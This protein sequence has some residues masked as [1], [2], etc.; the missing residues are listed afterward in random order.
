MPA[1]SRDGLAPD[2]IHNRFIFDY[3]HGLSL[4][5]AGNT[6]TADLERL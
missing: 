1:K 3:S 5:F 2:Y 6:A 4:D